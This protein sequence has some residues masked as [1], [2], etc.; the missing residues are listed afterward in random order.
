MKK[1]KIKNKDLDNSDQISGHPKNTVTK[2]EKKMKIEQNKLVH[3]NTQLQNEK[4]TLAKL[5]KEMEEAYFL[6]VKYQT[7][8]DKMQKNLGYIFMSH[9]VEGDIYTFADGA[10]FNYATQDFTFPATNH[11]EV[12]HLYHIS[13]G[14][15]VLSTGI[16]ENFVHLNL[17]SVNYQDK[18][19]YRQI[20]EDKN[21]N[22][23]TFGKDDSIQMMEIYTAILEQNLKVELIAEGGGIMGTESGNFYRDSN[24][25]AEAYS[26]DGFKNTGLTVYRADKGSVLTLKV[27]TWG[28]KMIPAKFSPY[29]SQFTKLKSKY[30]DLTEIDLYTGIRAK[31]YA[32]YWLFYLKLTV[33]QWIKKPEDQSKILKAL[34]GAKVKTVSFINGKVQAKV[35]AFV[36]E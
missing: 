29:Q 17:S 30:P 20:L 10:T 26:A 18:F 12:F 11:A 35:P 23:I 15:R 22:L 31:H 34:S 32:D 9:E 4:S 27:T 19:T 6:L 21:P 36:L 2:T 13:F 25:V 1:K 28:E 3:L 5:K 24:L 16:E 33:P 14:E 7:L 8:Y